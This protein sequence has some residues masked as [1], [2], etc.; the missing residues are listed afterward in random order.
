[1]IPGFWELIVILLIVLVIFGGRR[2]P[3]I[4]GGMGKGIRIFKKNIDPE[5]PADPQT[6]TAPAEQPKE[7]PHPIEPK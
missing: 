4:M 1:M 7:K 5:S 2:I 3:E 6:P